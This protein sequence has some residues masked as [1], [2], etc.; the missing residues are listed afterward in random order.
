M[1]SLTKPSGPL[2][3]K[4]YWRRRVIVLAVALV[5]VV[6]L[7]RLFS[8]GSDA[9]SDA[10]AAS[11][12]SSS[13]AGRMADAVPTVTPSQTPAGPPSVTEDAAPSEPSGAE[14]T[15]GDTEPAQPST[16]VA[17]QGDCLASDVSVEPKVKDQPAG[18]DI[19]VRLELTTTDS[20]ACTW[21]VSRDTLTMKITSGSDDIWFSSECPKAMPE[22]RVVVTNEDPT[23]VKMTWDA[24]R[25]DDG[26]TR[27]RLWALPGT[28]HLEA[29]ALGGEPA[30]TAFMLD[31]PTPR[32]ITPKPEPKKKSDKKA[33]EK[34]KSDR[35]QKNDG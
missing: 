30:E 11:G 2:P 33:G 7:G 15:G 20:P 29:A 5:L 24:R 25:S 16:S 8:G 3:E 12:D 22:E 6:G 27:Q 1:S 17:P 13:M 4:V 26:C 18:R 23:V 31:T 9:S 34:K 35:K 28:Y 10:S 21:T 19:K 32:T 14:T